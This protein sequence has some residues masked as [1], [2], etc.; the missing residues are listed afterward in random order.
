M[1]IACQSIEL[2]NYYGLLNNLKHKTEIF[3]SIIE[4][5]INKFCLCYETKCMA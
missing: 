4:I 2:Q 3:I 5:P 1:C